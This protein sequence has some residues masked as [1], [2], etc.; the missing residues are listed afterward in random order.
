MLLSEVR[1]Q[2]S[3]LEGQLDTARDEAERL[4]ANLNM[5]KHKYEQNHNQLQ[6]MEATV[7]S[8]Q[9]KLQDCRARVRG[10]RFNRTYD[11]AMSCT[12]Y[13]SVGL[14]HCLQ[15]TGQPDQG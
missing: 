14:T 11:T 3:V 1:Q 8:L 4:Q 15:S 7:N 12:R 13:T 5:Y 10:L 6:H 2:V 9:E